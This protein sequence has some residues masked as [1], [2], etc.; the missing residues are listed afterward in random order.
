MILRIAGGDAR[1]I[2]LA[3]YLKKR[4][5]SVQLDDQGETS[6]HRRPEADTLILPLP[7][8]RDGVHLFAPLRTRPIL[9]EEVL[10]NFHGDLLFGGLLPTALP[11]K[12]KKIDYYAAREVVWRNAALTAECAVGLSI[13]SIP[14]GLEGLPVLICGAGRIGLLLA[15]KLAALGAS[16]L[17]A[18]RREDSLAEA[19]ANGFRAAAYEDVPYRRFLLVC[20]TVPAPVLTRERL[21]ALPAGATLMELASPP[22]GFDRNEAEKAGLHTISAGG[23]PGKYCPAG[24][25]AVLGEYIIK[26]LDLYGE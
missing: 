11:F 4:G 26:E 6:I 14:Q 25:A 13:I 17:V 5:L 22:G 16:P 2:Y 20:N 7:V 12:G 3:E 9:L 8:S 18:A 23:L 15:K 10:A 1:Q 19:R 24:A 21:A